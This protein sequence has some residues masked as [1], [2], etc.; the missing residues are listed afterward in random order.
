[1]DLLCGSIILDVVPFFCF[2]ATVAA[3][4][5]RLPP[6]LFTRPPA[7]VEVSTP[8]FGRG[9]AKVEHRLGGP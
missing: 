9:G 4:G 8:V 6:V 7:A 5:P 1:L 3:A 2:S